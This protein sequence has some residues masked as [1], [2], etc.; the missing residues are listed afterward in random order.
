MANVIDSLN[1]GNN[2]YPFTLPYGSC[3][4]AAATAAKAV[5]VS[6]F[7]LETGARI[8]VKFTVTNTASSPTLNVNSTGAKAI[9]YKGAAITAGYLA[10]NKTYEFIYNGTQWDLIGDV[11]TNTTYTFN[12]AVSTIKDSNLTTSRALVSNS[13]GKVAVSDVTSTELGYLDGV[14]SN[15]QTQLNTKVDAD[16]VASRGEN[17]VTNGTALLGDNT[18]FSNFTYDGSDTYYAGGCFKHTGICWGKVTDEYIPVDPSQTYTLSYYIKPENSTMT[19]YD[20]IDMFDIDKKQILAKHVMWTSGSTTTL[21]Q[22]LKD[23][24]TVVYL[25]SAT[26]FN[27]TTAKSHQMG[28]IFWNYTSSKG[29]TYPVET[30]SRN[31]YH[32]L[33]TTPASAINKTNHTI[34]LDSAWS[35][36]T[37]PAGTSV[38]QCSAGGVYVYGN[39][40]YTCPNA[41]DTWTHKT[42]TINGVGKNNA[43]GKFREGTAFIKVGWLLNYNG[44]NRDGKITKISTVTLSQ[45]ANNSHTHDDRYYTES[46]IDT[47]VSTLNTAISG[48]AAS[49]HTHTIANVTGL[50]TT[51]DALEAAI[52]SSGSG[53]SS[54]TGSEIVEVTGDLTLNSSHAGKFLM[55]NSSSFVTITVPNISIGMEVEIFRYGSGSVYIQYSDVCFAIPGDSDITASSQYISDR[56]SSVVLKQLTDSVWSI[57]G[58]L[59]K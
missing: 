31:V 38:S 12:G 37:I 19:S 18:N 8:A 35:N 24:D 53:G 51:L 20:Y 1:Y 10:A 58:A 52:G 45:Q 47:K 55:V 11:D 42:A 9:Y 14:T 46:E 54:N 32:Y 4:T 17:M 5:T 6:N 15:I 50:Q 16:Y 48:K 25:T 40:N 2:V 29:Y 22:D 34:T 21:A 13:S 59:I 49:S 30:Y 26:G 28:L 57:Q 39:A 43:G 41:P 44:T 7:S 33:W 3:S 36:G 23:G 27:T 56:Y